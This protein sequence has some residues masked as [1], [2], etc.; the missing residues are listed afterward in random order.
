M[1]LMKRIFLLLI[2]ALSLFAC[3]KGNNFP[4]QETIT[5]GG[6]WG[7]RIG[8][9]FADVYA[10]LQT[11]GK[12]KNFD[13]V[14]LVYLQ[15]LASPEELKPHLDYYNAFTL[16]SNSAVINH[17][18]VQF[19]E[20]KVTSIS[21]GGALP[22]DVAKWPSGSPDDIAIHVGDPVSDLYTKVAAIYQLPAYGIHQIILP[23]KPLARSFDPAM[24]GQ[25]EW[26]FSFTTNIRP[27]VTGTSFVRLYFGNG[28]LVKIYHQYNEWT[29]VID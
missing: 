22:D 23:D 2:P 29:Y 11:L 18:L 14:S 19:A 24:A 1:T 25:N 21:A 13:A 15:P 6:K 12:E 3:K 28:K 5:I 20:D 27:S 10:Q 7:I 17:V 16:M 9:S 8:S 26:A 4:T